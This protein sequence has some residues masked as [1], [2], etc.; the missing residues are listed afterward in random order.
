MADAA[1]TVLVVDDR[2]EI[3]LLLRVALGKYVEV[4]EAVDGTQALQQIR[5]HR[6]AVVLL[7]LM[8]PGQMSGLQVLET[9]RADPALRDTII[10]V[11]TARGQVSDRASAESRGAD[12][13]FVKPFSPQAIVAWVQYELQSRPKSN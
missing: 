2:G 13:F 5:M 9:V 6:P 4:I 12:A 3:R 7:D 8:M 11:I 1:D 10:G